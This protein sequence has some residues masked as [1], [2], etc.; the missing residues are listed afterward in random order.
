MGLGTIDSPRPRVED[1]YGEWHASS[2]IEKIIGENWAR[3]FG[4]VLG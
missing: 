1:C 3:D 4:E 2:A